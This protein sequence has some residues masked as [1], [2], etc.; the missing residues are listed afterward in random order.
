M[1]LW[2]IH[3][4][5]LPWL[6]LSDPNR[7]RDVARSLVMMANEGGHLPRWPLANVYTGC[8]VGDH[9]FSFIA[10]ACVK[11]VEGVDFSQVSR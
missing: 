3:R 9:V 2:D 5:Q 11:D 1:S 7:A 6:I 10:D 4:T 8:M